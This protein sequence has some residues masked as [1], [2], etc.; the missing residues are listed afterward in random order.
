[1]YDAAVSESNDTVDLDRALQDT[2]DS[3][4]I[5][6]YNKELAKLQPLLEAGGKSLQKRRE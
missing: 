1:M 2:K 3:L 4:K 5:D 6:E